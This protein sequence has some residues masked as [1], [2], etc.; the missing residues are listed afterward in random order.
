ME[1]SPP[2]LQTDDV[3][4]D[5]ALRW[6]YRFKTGEE[7]LRVLLSNVTCVLVFFISSLLILLLMPFYPTAMAVFL[8]LLFGALAFR[9]P[10]VSLGLILAFAAPAYSYQLGGIAWA[11]AVMGALALALPFSV[12]KLPGA[13]LGCVT[14]LAAGVLMLTPA[15]YLSLPLLAIISLLRIKG[16]ASSGLWGVMMFLVVYLPFLF[17]LQPPDT[18][19]A[20][21]PLFLAVDYPERPGLDILQLDS[22]KAAFSTQ[23]Y[24]GIV[25]F[26][27]VSDYFLE[28]WSGVVL[29]LAILVSILSIP[30]LLN[31]SKKLG[32]SNHVLHDLLPLF[33]L[34][35]VEI[36]FLVPMLLLRSP[37][38]YHTGFD[39]WGNI[40][41]LTTI[42]LALGLMA[43]GFD[44]WLRRRNLKVG[45]GGELTVLL[46]EL[47]DYLEDSKRRLQQ[48]A[49]VCRHRGLEDEKSA[50]LQWE[51]KVTL[52]LESMNALDLSKLEVSWTEFTNMRSQ[53][54][55]LQDQIENKLFDH[56]DTSKRV[57]QE[58][59]NGALELG[60][61]VT[62][63][64]IQALTVMF[65]DR[66][67]G[68]AL[69]NQ[70]MLNDAF[71][72]L[73]VSL[74]STGEMLADT[75]KEEIDPE[76]SLTT[77]DIGRGF[78]D[79]CRYEA[80][81]QTILEDLQIIDGRIESPIH[82]LASRII[83]MST[84]LKKVT[85][86]HLIPVFELLGDSESVKKCY[87]NIV[88]LE[89]VDKSVHNSGTLADLISIVDQSRTLS[90]LATSMVSELKHKIARVEAD[91]DRRC[92]S[93]YK[94]GRNIHLA[95]DTQQL[96]NAIESTS[97]GLTISSRLS[98]IEKAVQ[99]I[100]QQAK[101]IKDYSRS[102][103]FLINYPIVETI[104]DDN[105]KKKKTVENSYLPVAP[106]YAIEYLKM[107][108]AIHHDYVIFEPRQGYI[109]RK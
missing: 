75:V 14:G 60:M 88:Q 40:A 89:T 2:S 96:L 5:Q 98:I 35:S 50:V 90:D 36:L 102:N 37:L 1:T 86:S 3:S 49:S 73:A 56:L 103:E 18:T 59:I 25:G 85:V 34:L 63:T 93:K 38:G 27:G 52:T 45:M 64:A 33:S 46:L 23:E 79:Q 32:E 20:T 107:Y 31:L 51:E 67:Y 21:V 81:A 16:A 92:P 8:S 24:E 9:W 7:T 12:S 83:T 66:D 109:K 53:L 87:R 69:N 44:T 54:M 70:Q 72:D 80:A 95:G 74:V 39:S 84:N 91:N 57:Y 58:T 13:A 43:F 100:E 30:A 11:A 68:N 17:M 41:I 104:I 105:L 82:E 4:Y 77:I 55:D 47:Y 101:I 78:L 6:Q 15:F 28:G 42:M 106:K 10:A 22:L 26:P 62:E 108:S 71:K 94:W 29:I 48:M 61:P 76:F 99:A 65:E 19:G 97:S